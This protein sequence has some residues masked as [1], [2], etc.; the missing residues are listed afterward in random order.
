MSVQVLRDGE[1]PLIE[2]DDQLRVFLDD[3]NYVHFV[4]VAMRPG[5]GEC[6]TLLEHSEYKPLTP[7]NDL[8]HLRVFEWEEILWY[9]ASIP[10]DERRLM[11]DAADECGLRTTKDKMA[12]LGQNGMSIFPFHNDRVYTLLNKSNHP[13]YKNNPAINSQLLQEECEHIDAIKMYYSGK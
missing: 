7:R 11:E 10:S 2:T 1:P 5:V 6:F 8:F 13:V 3:E 4:A 12:I 9:F